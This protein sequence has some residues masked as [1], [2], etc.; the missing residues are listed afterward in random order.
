MHH[1][2]TYFHTCGKAV[3]NEP[4]DFGFEQGEQILNPQGE[5]LVKGPYVA[6]TFTVSVEQAYIVI[7][8]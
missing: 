1:C 7:E 5:R 6:E 8:V 3:E 4:P 2:I